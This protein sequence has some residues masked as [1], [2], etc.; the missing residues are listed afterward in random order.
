MRSHQTPSM[1]FAA[2]AY[3][4]SVFVVGFVLGT[5]R[6]MIVERALGAP[7]ATLIEIPIML[8]ASWW[9]CATNIRRLG[10]SP[11]LGERILMGLIAF[12]LLLSAETVL[13]VYGFG[14]S[15]VDQ[16]KAYQHLDKAMGLAA[17]VAFAAFPAIQMQLMAT[18][19]R[20][21]D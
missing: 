10:V 14:Q 16:L 8:A 4:G 2:A 3:A 17:Q 20:H 9:L 15:L 11:A 13:G 12:V 1:L 18:Q 19:E 5:I 6:V 7:L 21:C